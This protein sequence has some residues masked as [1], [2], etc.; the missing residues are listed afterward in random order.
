M[1]RE[2]S[3][4]GNSMRRAIPIAALTLV[5]VAAFE[6]SHVAS[7]PPLPSF[8]AVRAAYRPSDTVLLDRHGEIVHEMRIDMH[9]RRLRW[10][11]LADV[12]PALVRAV[13]ASED[14]HF[15]SHSGVDLRAVAAA[16][17]SQIERS[18]RRWL[19]STPPAPRGASTITMQLVGLLDPHLRHRGTPRSLSAKWQQM[20]AAWALERRWSKDEIL[21]AY[22]NL[23]TFRGEVQ[24]VSAAAHALYGKEPHGLDQAESAVLAA[25]VRAPNASLP[26]LRQRAVALDRTLFAGNDVPGIDTAAARAV[27]APRHGGPRIRLAPHL[28]RRLLRASEPYATVSTLDASLQR[29][30][31]SSVRRHLLAIRDRSVRDAAVLAVDNASGEVLAYVG[32]SGSLSTAPQVDGVRARRQAGSTLKP[33]LY[34]LA[35]DHRLL[36]PASLLE[37][38]PLEIA[39]DGGVYR[40]RNYDN[41][42]HGLVSARTALASSLNVPAVRTLELLGGDAFV[43]QLR[44]LG[45]S[46]LIENGD[47]YGPALALG[48]AEVTLWELVDAYRSLADGGEWSP[49]HATFGDTGDRRRV[50]SPQAAFLVADILSDRGARS[51][52][53]GL[54]SLLSTPFWTAVKTGTSKDM[55]DNWCVGFSRRYTVGVWVG[56]F[57]GA[58]MHDVSGVSGAAPIWQDVMRR[59]HRHVASDPPD[60]PPGVLRRDVVFPRDAEAER[61]DWFLAGTEPSPAQPLL[62]HQPRIRTPADGSILALD[63]DIPAEDQRVAFRADGGKD[64]AWQLDGND[65]GR[66]DRPLLW[67]PVSGR[68]RLAL[69]DR[70]GKEIDSAAFLV[71]G[72][73][74][75]PVPSLH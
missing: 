1:Q 18:G 46:G 62:A 54:E 36:T 53:F 29:Y 16:A 68:H 13:I 27:E 49:L 42:F 25:L 70:E 52:T 40:P 15:Y 51:V 6:L 47:Y 60:P 66:A 41:L 17:L 69:R 30:V 43:A 63:P 59:L 20:R 73:K 35:F 61:R 64:L 48:S 2:T 50:Y 32:S 37:D 24:G 8:A 38:A 5:A 56:N 45:F 39:V 10:T 9:G 65:L 72:Q 11:A 28:A 21:E 26:V 67:P 74:H 19:G 75:P 23:V 4:R 7:I 33:F 14:R 55:R 57:S 34:G 71:R 58:P 44:A 31:E 3:K 22:L 12:S